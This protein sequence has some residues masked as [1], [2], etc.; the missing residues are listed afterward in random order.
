MQLTTTRKLTLCYLMALGLI[1]ALSIGSHFVFNDTL[2]ANEGS[3]AVINLSG[4]QRMLTMRIT[5]SAL[6]LQSGD[7]TARAPLRQAIR[8]YRLA[9]RKLVGLAND[10][11]TAELVSTRLQDTY[12][13]AVDL[14]QQSARLLA[15]ASRL[16]AAP[17]ASAQPADRRASEAKD[18]AEIVALS[19]GPLLKGL[20]QVVMIHQMESEAQTRRLELIQWLI[21]GVVLATL[22]IEALF[23]FRPMITRMALYI[24]QLLDLADNDY[25]TGVA[26]RRAFT[27][28]AAA[29]IERA[30]RHGHELSV[31]VL[32]ADH[33][34]QIN[35]R[36]GHLA[37]DAVLVALAGTLVNVA[38]Q[39]DVVGRI[40]GEEFAL[41]LP[42]TAL[43]KAGVVAERI[44]RAVADHPVDAYGS[45]VEV[46]VSIGLASV[47]LDVAEPLKAALLTAD[48]MLY[49]AKDAGRNCVWPHLVSADALMA[50]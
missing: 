33:F 50:G 15:A 6:E 35:D 16:A 40:G 14:D 34:K 37:G 32:D 28:R 27:T 10:P 7:E 5:A 8:E 3:A 31:L 25:L 21:L 24:K 19:R 46:T 2:R 20:E 47:P 39:E 9:H 48:K 13:G 26:N 30:R 45:Q 4:R 12:Y 1:A 44:R 41:L 38:R 29:E 11:H 36:H 42:Q 49:K 22:A 18:V 17:A 23:I 43:A